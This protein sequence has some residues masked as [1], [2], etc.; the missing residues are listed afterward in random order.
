[1]RTNYVKNVLNTA[2]HSMAVLLFGAS[3]GTAQSVNLT[4]GPTTASMPD[5]SSVPMWGYSCGTATSGSSV[6]VSCAAANG[7]SGWSPVIITVSGANPSL[8]IHLTNNLSFTGISLPTSIM[9]V[10]QI[11]GGLGAPTTVAG[12]THSA[13]SNATWPIAGGAADNFTPPAQGPRV[14]SFGTEVAVGTPTDLMWTNLKPGT[15]LLESG[16]HPSI[17]ANMG[18]ISMLV[19]TQAPAS[20]TA[21]ETS[22]GTAYPNVSYDAEVP[23]ILS[24]IDPVMNS[25][26]SQAVNTV[27]FLEANVWS[28]QPGGCGNPS[29]GSTYLTCYPPVVNYTP[30]YYLINGVAFNR[31]NA[32]SSLFPTSPANTITPA[33]GNQSLL[34]RLVNAGSHMHVPSIVGSQVTVPSTSTNPGSPSTVGGFWMVAEDGNPLPGNPHVQNEVFMAAG[35]TYDVMVN[36]PPTGANALAV[37]DREL[38]LSANKIIRDSGMLAYVGVNGSAA[39]NAA[40][41]GTPVA[42]PD[43]YGGVLAGVTLNVSDP[44]KG[45]IANDVNIFGVAAS[46]A[47]AHG[48]LT[49]NTDGSFTYVADNTWPSPSSPGTTTTDSFNYCGNG[50]A[51][52]TTVTLN[53]G[54]PE[55]SGNINVL[56]TTW[57]S[58]VATLIKVPSPGVLTGATDAAGLPLTVDLSTVT[59]LCASAPVAP[60]VIPDAKGGFTFLST[61]QGSVQFT[62][63]AQNAQGVHSGTATATVNFP[64]GSGL[65]VSVTDPK[66]GA[67][68]TDYRWI[69]E[70]DRSFFTDPGCTT[71]PPP[72]TSSVTGL[73][74]LKTSS[75]TVPELGTNFHTS[76]MPY[77]AQ[78]CTGPV[79]CEQGQM[80]V[81]PTSGNHV[82]AV[83]DVG[84]G[85]CRPDT[86]GNG[87]TPVTPDQVAL[88]PTK[89]YYISVLPGDAADPFNNANGDPACANYDPTATGCGHSM[90]G[91]PIAPAQSAVTVVVERDP[92]PPAKLAVNVYEDD[93]PL[94]GEQDSGGGVDILA[95]NE[96][97]LGSFN[98]ILWDD[99]GGS[100]DVTGQMTYD[101]FNQPLSNSLDGT[102]DPLTGKNACPVTVQG[103]SSNPSGI[104]GMITVCPTYESDGTTLSPLAGQAVIANLMPGR[105]SV[106][107][108]P[109]ADRIA[110]GEEWLQTNTLDGQ[111][112][113]DSFLRIGEPAYFQ[114]FG[115]ANY[116]VSIGFANPGII[117]ARKAGV[118]GGTDPNITGA[119]CG[120]TVTGKVTTERMSRTPDE[121]LYSSGSHD[122]FYWTQ[123]YVSFGDPDGEDFAFTKCNADG[124]FTLTGLPDGDWRVTVFDQWNDMLVD[125][126]ST[127]VGLSAG[128]TNGTTNMGDIATNQWQAN[129]YTRTFIDKTSTG[130][131]NSD[132]P[133]IPLINTTVRYRDGSLANN[134]GTDF[135]GTAN[136]NETFPL[137]N[138]YVVETDTTRYKNTGTHTVYDAGGPADQSASCGQ[139]GYPP[140]G[141]STIGKFLAN[142]YEQNPLPGLLAVPG[143]VYC[144]DADCTSESILNVPASRGETTS[145]STGRI[146]NPWLGGVEGWQGFSGQNNFV[147]FGKAPYTA[148]ENGGIKGHVVYASTRPFDDPQ[149]LVQTQWEPLVPHVTMNLYAEGVAADGVTPTLTL[150]DTTQTTSWDDWA[151]GFHLGPD[152]IT[153]VPNMNCPGQSTGDLFYFSLVNQPQYLDLYGNVMH[154][155][156]STTALPFSSQ[157]KCYDGMHNWNQVQPAVYDG[158]Y[159]FPSITSYD[160]VTGKPKGTNCTNTTYCTTDPAT[161]LYAG[162]PMLKAGKY[163]VEVVPP[164]GYEIVKEEDKNILIGDNFIAP[165]TQEF[166]GLGD[167]FILPDQAQIANMYNQWNAQNP[168]QSLGAGVNNGLVPGFAP[169]PTWPCVGESHIVPD[170]ISLFPQ[171]AEVAPFAGAT[172]NL[173]DRKEVTLNDQRSAIAKF[174][175][176]TSTHKAS[177]F[178]GVITDDFTSEFDPFSPQFGEKFAPANMPIALRDW[179]GAEIGR[180]YSDWWGDYDGLVYSTWEVNPPNPTGY[181][182]N[183]MVMCMNDK[184]PIPGTNNTDPL[185]NSHYSQFCYELPFMPGQTDYLDTPVV[186][187]SAFS[188]GYNH[189]DCAYPD[190]T[191]AIARLDGDG[192]SGGPWASA[193]GVNLTITSLG[194][195]PVNN[196]G[197]S[198]PQATSAPFNAKTVNR[199][200]GFG[201]QCTSPTAGNVACNTLSSV[202]IGG[203]SAPIT[204]WGDGSIT[205]TVPS[206][207]PACAIQQQAQYGGL[208][209]SCG[210][211]VITAGNGKQSVDAV[212]LTIGG[213]APTYVTSANP[214]TS[215]STGSIQQAIDVAQPGDLILIPPGTYYEMLLM[216]KP[217]RLQGFGA[218]TTTIDA[219]AQPAG[220]LDPW[221]RQVDCLFGLSLDG[222]PST[223]NSDPAVTSTNTNPYDASGTYSCGSTNGT[224]WGGFNGAFNNPQVDRLPLEGIVGWDT[225]VNGNLAQ[226]LQEPTLMGA[227][228]GAGITVLGKGVNVPSNS[229]SSYYGSGA[230]ATFPTGTLNLSAA[231]CGGTGSNPYPS[232]F[233]CNPSRI[234][235]LTVTDASAGGGGIFTHAWTHNL[236]ISNNRVYGNIGTLSGGIN[237]GQGEFPDAYLNGVT[238]DT[239]PGSCLDGTGLP[240]N[241]QLPYC[242]QVNMNVHNNSVTANTSIGDEL[243]SAT[244]AGAGGVSFC[245]GSDYYKFNY[246]WICG[247]MSTG[248]G[249][250]L[251]HLG[252]IWNGDIEHNSILFNQSLNPTIPT[253]GGGIIVMGAAPDGNQIV[254]G[255]S[256]E[257]GSVVDN[258]CV[259]GLSDGTGPGLIINA[260]LIMGNAAEA[261]SGGGLRFQAVNGTD[262]PRWFNDTVGGVKHA[263]QYWNGVTVTNNII[264]NNVAGWDGGGVSLE[265]SLKVS[266]INNTIASNDSTATAGV[267]FNT[268]G[269]PLASSQSG[270]G[271]QTVNPNTSAPQPAGIV[272]MQNSPQLTGGLPTGQGTIACPPNNTNAKGDCAVYSIPYLA[273]DLIWQNRSFQVGVGSLSA[274]YQQNLVTLYNAAFSGGTYG[275]ALLPQ[276]ATGQCV[277]NSSYWDLGFR[278][279]TGPGAPSTISGVTAQLKPTY[280]LL[281]NSAEDKGTKNID[282]ANPALLSEYCNGSRTP[283][284]FAAGTWNVPPGISDA[285]VPNPIFNL[286]PAATVDEGNNWINMVWGPL[287]MVNP[288]TNLTLGNYALA[289]SSPAIDYVPSTS[290]TYAVA[291]GTDFFGNPRPDPVNPN[292]F[293]IGAVEYQGAIAAPTIT[294][295]SPA[296]GVRKSTVLVTITGTNLNTT[297]SVAVSGTGVSVSGLTVVNSTTVTATFTIS[298]SATLGARTVT[299]TTAANSTATTT[300]TVITPSLTSVTPNTGTQGTTVN[301]TFAGKGLASTTGIGGWGS[302]VTISNIVSSDTQVT[303]TFT[304]AAGTAL[305]TRNLYLITSAGPTN[306]V[307]FTVTGPSI[308]SINPSTGTRGTAVNVTFTGTGLASTTGVGGWGPSVTVSNIVASN[309]QV[310]ATFTISVGTTLGSRN[311]YLITSSGP[312]NTVPFTVTAPALTSIAPSTGTQGTTVNVTFTGTGLSG[313]TGV[314]GWGPTVPV[315]NVVVV[316]STQVT[317]T[318]TIGATAQ[319]GSHNLYLIT[320]GGNTN[321]VH[322]TV[323]AP[324][325]T[326]VTPSTGARGSTVNVTFV[327]TGLA[328]TTGVGGWGNSVTVSNIVASSTQVTATFTLGAGVTLGTHNLYLISASGKTNSLPFTVTAPALTSISPT[329]GAQGSTVNVTFTGTGLASATGVG[330]WGSSTTISNLVAT[331][332]QVTAT[333]NIGTS[334]FLGARNLYLITGGGNTNTVQFTVTAH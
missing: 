55:T 45:V 52:C 292:R 313:T 258:D 226:L 165:V 78:G 303:A 48:T 214:M 124:T 269:A 233:W 272:T 240:A 218:A 128:A 51:A 308:A 105:F 192:A 34:V 37:Y 138:W 195:Q 234:D 188:A 172:R 162:V 114:E 173:C 197:Y 88:D 145:N 256:I 179:T 332:T 129:V 80:M 331:D 310:A 334:A 190:A 296:E 210:Q 206:N 66:S 36:V 113:H 58:R 96:P 291:P 205:V 301:V 108:I 227:Y 241:T 16:T 159:S 177:K 134:L 280:S 170:Y 44:S 43:T 330:G 248:D 11:G 71:N 68:L 212:T 285:T 229:T 139:T 305:G 38:S 140:C 228:E 295:I 120:N 8:T 1:M 21:T 326:S 189:P 325:I 118:C 147:E 225:T 317:A 27:G 267:L 144:A 252:F 110:R 207:V 281:T 87:K 193:A 98:V 217:V 245:T 119:N 152:G 125:G 219:N 283:P 74:C 77:V 184:G 185:Y 150:V 329:S 39:P 31:S 268:I 223:S 102:I 32:S 194:D 65:N 262:V 117:N 18:L 143:S 57:N 221:R 309:T 149:S 274:T 270:G 186:P 94:N 153:M 253:N 136:F 30:L 328:G 314:G 91:A 169:E 208:P 327:G 62:F 41:T 181:S 50:G 276:T 156:G 215:A 209:A 211:V 250:G 4:A 287:S 199:H 175:L 112:A 198:G 13:Q 302:S 213:K 42:N 22:P 237:V 85:V 273:N 244:P 79:S 282:G 265:D 35:K 277:S 251:S 23:M 297:N 230:E 180:V 167:I 246:N 239:D 103:N 183:M 202:T 104:T 307:P 279:D 168:T 47:P 231:D 9:I 115:P 155:S 135:T 148:G 249:G 76:D 109:G 318:F 14:Q 158:M 333:F 315:S 176:F 133:G 123:C 299:L 322:F 107:A 28:G 92:F 15:Y 61:G 293:D 300:F 72:A 46:S 160:S 286:T 121:R 29:S 89:R 54:T 90:G 182:P 200:Y 127:P 122:S 220:K 312:T 132:D 243:F 67:V 95:T 60:C 224:A 259:P 56:N 316:S 271:N 154:G 40:G 324:A 238:R 20:T 7:G 254:N 201:A 63:Q 222:Q 6:A 266:L 99:M 321:S 216:W 86:S 97:G 19:V 163:V 146:D 111:K 232:S 17:Q 12:P 33:T 84:N 298:S 323:T 257:C 69:I 24:E 235:G 294:G 161:D 171:S 204:S 275:A 236:E 151:Q 64:A 130:V 320:T 3:I 288:V 126:L 26:I 261:G 264:T 260:N 289:Q 5:G 100:G 306:T 196:Y 49:L 81:D 53:A 164:A 304:I 73:A 247:N 255:A 10:G 70:E 142:T 116:H 174:Y 178:T 106:Q 290:P 311:L 131:S 101:M 157:Y 25:M 284:E 263:Y 137:F 2:V 75:G 166:G 83:C 141:S 278:G 242:F 187:T 191:P 59:N 319:L 203:I 93:F 82:N